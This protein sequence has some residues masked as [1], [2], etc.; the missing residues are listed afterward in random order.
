MAIFWT[1][2]SGMYNCFDEWYWSWSCCFWCLE[3]S[4]SYLFWD[5]WVFITY[6]V[7]GV[8]GQSLL[9]K[10]THSMMDTQFPMK[11][12]LGACNYHVHPGAIQF[13]LWQPWCN[14]P[15]KHGWQMYIFGITMSME[16]KLARHIPSWLI[17]L[18]IGV[19]GWITIVT[20]I[21]RLQ[22]CHHT[23]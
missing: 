1:S 19:A 22:G 9:I 23:H 6:Y 12:L 7:Y 2:G 3:I 4:W 21:V 14:K 11:V 15:R 13:I 5:I 20:C 17:F 10:S 8:S 18:Y 16:K